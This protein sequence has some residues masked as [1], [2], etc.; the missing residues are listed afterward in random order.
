MQQELFEVRDMRHKEKFQID[1]EYL[2]G[3]AKKCGVYATGVYISLCRHA[4]KEQNCFP[5]LNKIAEELAVSKSQ[6]RRA[7]KI[8]I[9]HNIIKVK[10]LGKKLNNRYYLIDKSEWSGRTLTVSPQN[11]HLYP[12]R[13]LH[14]KDTQLRNTHIRESNY[15]MFYKGQPVIKDFGKLYVLQRGDKILF[16]GKESDIDYEMQ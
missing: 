15:K 13:T 14:S 1:D 16:T 10:R 2:N 6:V 3:Y 7:I 12:G 5:S 8:L 9:K 11:T 4:N